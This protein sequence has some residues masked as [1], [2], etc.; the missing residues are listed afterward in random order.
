MEIKSNRQVER[1][2]KYIRAPIK[3]A[4]PSMDDMQSRKNP[5]SRPTRPDTFNPKR[6]GSL[7]NCKKE[8]KVHARTFVKPGCPS[9][10]VTA[11]E[12]RYETL[13]SEISESISEDDYEWMFDERIEDSVAESY[14]EL[15][16]EEYGKYELT[17]EIQ[18]NFT[19]M[20][21]LSK[22]PMYLSLIHICR[23]RRLL[24]C[25]SRWSPYH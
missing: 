21:F 3:I 24:T 17:R 9:C 5:F 25:R 13:T 12:R 4:V 19:I 14:E 2:G 18:H 1:T 11:S 16:T 22:A 8:D 15:K 20:R 23:C 7:V 6:T 10:P